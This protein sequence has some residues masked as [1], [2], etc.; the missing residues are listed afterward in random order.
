MKQQTR[1][2]FLNTATRSLGVF[3]AMAQSDSLFAQSSGERPPRADG[4]TVLNPRARVP[5]GLI[6]D[7]ST[8]LVNLN[9][10][11]MSQ[12]DLT[13]GGANATYNKNWREWPAEIPDAFVRKFG[14][15]CAEHGVKGKYSIVPYPAC[16]GR[17]DR[18]LPGWSQRELEASLELVRT[19]IMPN[20]DIHPEMVT[21]TRVID[22][23]TGHP[24]PDASPKFME[25][26][27]WTTG[28]SVDE[29]A[30]YM[31]Y[32]LRILKNVG[33]PCEGITTPG[34]FGTRA[35]PQLAQATL[36]SVRDVFGAEIPH[37]FRDLF[38]RGEQSVAPRVEYASGLETADPRCVVS[39]LGCTGDWTGGWDCTPPAGVDRFIT[40]DLQ[41]GR[42]V[43]VI[44]R[45]EPALILAHWTGVYWNGQELGFKI[46]QEVVR[47]LHARFDNL[48]WMKLSEVARY[49]A[50]KELTRVERNG[51]ALRLR[52]PFACP[53]FTVRLEAAENQTPTLRVNQE[54][55]PLREVNAPLKLVAGTWCRDGKFVNV[56]FALP[57]GASEIRIAG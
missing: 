3:T 41:R 2:Q 42:M 16:V 31:A 5:V 6:I 40:E 44:Q 34:G 24:Y 51:G 39:V 36:Q 46:F 43:E 48:V 21:H 38:D 14:E 20:W 55:K 19:L 35:R 26:W 32:A 15:W 50:A 18:L 29:I 30:D 28:R 56:C 52:A 11:S 13:F 22:T 8:C 10:F 57:K 53:D 12:F 54:P 45:G 33:L 4:I 23:K 37:Y 25:N 49:W 1:R 17:L 7:D 27:E 9:R 47:R